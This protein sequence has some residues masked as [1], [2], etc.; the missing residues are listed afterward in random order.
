MCEASACSSGQYQFDDDGWTIEVS[1]QQGK[2]ASPYRAFAYLPFCHGAS[3]DCLDST[4]DI[5]IS[6]KTEDVSKV[7]AYVKLFFWGDGSNILGLLPPGAPGGQGGAYRLIAFPTTD[8]PNGWGGEYEIEDGRWYDVKMSFSPQSIT[9][10]IGG[11]SWTDTSFGDVRGLGSN[12]PQLGSYNFDYGSSW[13]TDSYKI[14]IGSVSGPGGAVARHSCDYSCFEACEG[15]PSP[16][17]PTPVP[18]PTPTPSACPGGSL[19]A[20]IDLCPPDQFATCVKECQ[21]E[22][23]GALV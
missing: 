1:S 2:G 3:M 11:Q 10:S 5:S 8:Y 22:C 19:D 17:V 16:P 7:S 9:V 13:S 21:V 6:F 4:F 20:C 12:G 15:D 18:V 23:G 14:T